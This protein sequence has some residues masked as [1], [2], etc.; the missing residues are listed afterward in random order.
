MGKISKSK[1]VA[2]ALCILIVTQMFQVVTI[3]VRSFA[4][5]GRETSSSANA[6][7]SLDMLSDSGL[8]GEYEG[9][10]EI[11][12]RGGGVLDRQLADALGIDQPEG[13]GSEGGDAEGGVPAITEDENQSDDEADTAG[14][15]SDGETVPAADDQKNDAGEAQDAD[16]K[17]GSSDP[18]GNES[19]E[20]VPADGTEGTETA[21]ASGESEEKP[22]ASLPILEEEPVETSASL[23]TTNVARSESKAIKS[24][25]TTKE[26]IPSL[27]ASKTENGINIQ[28]GGTKET[29]SGTDCVL[30]SATILDTSGTLMR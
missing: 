2:I 3:S 5:N 10:N 4:S 24:A 30:W 1:V 25:T 11:T 8:A 15:G 21:P 27:G 14:D 9:A 13:D 16:D 17:D 12:N 23:L 6:G 7:G 22:E 19:G 18:A 26:E 28:V 29:F 20:A